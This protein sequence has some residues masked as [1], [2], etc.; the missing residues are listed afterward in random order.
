MIFTRVCKSL[1]V[2]S[3]VRMVRVF[4]KM[5]PPWTAYHHPAHGDLSPPWNVSQF[6]TPATGL[7]DERYDAVCISG[8]GIR[9]KPKLVGSCLKL[10]LGCNVYEWG[11]QR[12]DEWG[13]KWSFVS[14]KNPEYPPCRGWIMSGNVSRRPSTF[15]EVCGSTHYP[16]FRD[17][18]LFRFP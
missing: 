8:C 13:T 2:K 14:P 12:V 7:Q 10:P 3:L 9:T 18:A 1:P 4:P 6:V 15:S 5:P 11:K 16:S 17:P